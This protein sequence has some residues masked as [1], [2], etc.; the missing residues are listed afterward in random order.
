MVFKQGD[1]ERSVAG[2]CGIGGGWERYSYS[3]K[4]SVLTQTSRQDG[5]GKMTKIELAGATIKAYPNNARIDELRLTPYHAYEIRLRDTVVPSKHAD[6]KKW[7]EAI[8]KAIQDAPKPEPTIGHAPTAAHKRWAGYMAVNTEEMREDLAKPKQ[9]SL[10]EIWSVQLVRWGNLLEPG[11]CYEILSKGYSDEKHFKR[12][13]ENFI[14]GFFT[15]TSGRIGQVEK[16]VNQSVDENKQWAVTQAGMPDGPNRSVTAITDQ[17]GMIDAH[18][19]VV[20]YHD[21]ELFKI[22]PVVRLAKDVLASFREAYKN[23][24]TWS[25]DECKGFDKYL[26][27]TAQTANVKY[28][29]TAGFD[30]V[31]HKQEEVRVNII[32]NMQDWETQNQI[33]LETVKKTEQLQEHAS[34]FETASSDL[35]WDRECKALKAR[36]VFLLII[37]IALALVGGLVYNFIPH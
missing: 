36:L 4:E 25:R 19:T 30:Q 11:Q 16:T 28:N 26:E 15:P 29:H 7:M 23:P 3:L 13:D 37:L 27:E 12:T 34:E 1:L 33:L 32:E 17:Q 5:T 20:I 10:A 21:K 18:L 24:G 31:V 22:P 35:K 8:L 6:M 14:L 2:F 9:D